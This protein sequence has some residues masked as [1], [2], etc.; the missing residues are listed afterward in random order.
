MKANMRKVQV[1]VKAVL[2]V[3]ALCAVQLVN[4]KQSLSFH[5]QGILSMLSKVSASTWSTDRLDEEKGASPEARV[6]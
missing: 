1:I 5:N 2:D 6:G 3:K 4:S